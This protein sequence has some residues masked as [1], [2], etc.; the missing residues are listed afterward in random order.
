[1]NFKNF[2]ITSDLIPPANPAPSNSFPSRFSC[3]HLYQT[4]TRSGRV[5]TNTRSRRP[6]L[7]PDDE[8]P[9]PSHPRRPTKGTVSSQTTNS[10]NRLM[11]TNYTEAVPSQTTNP[12]YQPKKK[13]TSI[14]K[15]THTQRIPIP[16]EIERKAGV[17]TIFVGKDWTEG[18][19]TGCNNIF[20]WRFLF[21]CFSS[22]SLLSLSSIDPEKTRTWGSRA[23][24]ITPPPPFWT[25]H[26]I[27][28]QKHRRPEALMGSSWTGDPLTP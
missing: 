6:S 3:P 10:R 21:F 4:N 25:P 17:K 11:T 27:D 2:F 23:C 18:V 19:T 8:L 28:T 9:E 5:S 20:F 16:W 22:F 1:V 14:P 15:K 12:C 13:N 7:I 26:L 24:S